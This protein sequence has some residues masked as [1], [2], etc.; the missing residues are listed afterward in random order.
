MALIK[1]TAGNKQMFFLPS[2][3]S[4]KDYTQKQLTQLTIYYN[5]ALCKIGRLRPGVAYSKDFE[6][7]RQFENSSGVMRSI[8]THAGARWAFKELTK[9]GLFEEARNAAYNK[10]FSIATHGVI[11]F[12]P[13]TTIFRI[14]PRDL[15]QKYLSRYVAQLKKW[16][17]TIFINSDTINSEEVKAMI[18]HIRNFIPFGCICVETMTVFQFDEFVKQYDD[19][20]TMS[21]STARTLSR[22]RRAA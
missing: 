3:V 17:E 5:Y 7:N 21:I 14:D 19:M 20:M 18:S 12:L 11:V 1:L 6:T 2:T 13:E 8:I 4:K 10:V 15:N 9:L 16:S 22:T